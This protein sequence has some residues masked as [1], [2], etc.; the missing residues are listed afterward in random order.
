MAQTVF[1]NPSKNRRKVHAFDVFLVCF[2]IFYGLLMVFP[3][4]NALLVSLVPESVYINNP[5]LIYPKQ[6]TLESYSY[7]VKADLIWN[8]YMI[9]IFEVVVGTTC[10]VLVTVSAGYV[11]SRRSFPFKNFFMNIIIF[12]MFFSGGFIPWYRLMISMGFKN[13][14]A[15][16]IVP[17]IIDTYNLLLARNYFGS[18]PHEIEESAKIDGAND[19]VILFKIY[20]PIAMPIIATITLFYAV[21]HWNNWYTSMLFLQK[22]ELQT[23][24]Y[25]LRRIIVDNTG[26][27]GASPLDSQIFSDGIK[28]ASIFFTMVP[29]MMVYPFIQRYFV[30][31]I[32]IG[33]I[34]G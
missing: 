25:V 14:L 18:L 8:A 13:N 2:F 17:G 16:L 11:L 30:K 9:T 24:S 15:V 4:Y 34:K 6:I 5:I 1:L 7:V 31:G 33:A 19:I 29:I 23:L 20:I 28:M 10:N 32:M 12:T 26:A 22:A 3:F 21:G 27:I